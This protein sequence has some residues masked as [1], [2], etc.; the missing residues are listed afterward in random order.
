MTRLYRLTHNNVELISDD[1]NNSTKEISG[2][3]NL[4]NLVMFSA[5]LFSNE[6][7]K[8]GMGDTDVSK[9]CNMSDWRRR[10]YAGTG[11]SQEE[12]EDVDI[13]DLPAKHTSQAGVIYA[14]TTQE[15]EEDKES[16]TAFL[17]AYHKPD[18]SKTIS[19]SRTAQ[20]TSEPTPEAQ[21]LI[22]S[23]GVTHIWLC[24]SDP[25]RRR[26]RYMTKCLEQLEQDVRAWR[27]SG[28]GSGIMTVHTIPAAFPG[29]VQFLPKNGFQGGDLVIGGENGK[30]LYWKEV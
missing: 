10:I 19:A 7:R 18:M 11:H 13:M 9:T 6:F 23:S 15:P 29:M 16:F 26:H 20:T 14:A 27:A 22:A 12:D 8:M 17:L 30:V 4:S 1:N 24:G 3:I 25:A 21:A 2:A 28:H 5:V